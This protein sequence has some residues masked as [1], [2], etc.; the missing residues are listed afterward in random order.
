MSIHVSKSAI[1]SSGSFPAGGISK[2]SYLSA[3]RRRLSSF[4]P[5]TT[6]APLS[7]PLAMPARESTIRLALSVPARRAS[8]E[9]HL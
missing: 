7:P 9:W 4:L 2:P 6:A 3:A 8:V 1:T 5:G